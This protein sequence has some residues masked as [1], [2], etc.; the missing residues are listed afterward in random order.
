MNKVTF[1]FKQVLSQ[2]RGHLGEKWNF[3][4]EGSLLSSPIVEDIDHDGKKEILFGTKDGKL[5]LLSMDGKIKWT[6]SITEKINDV[7]LMFLDSDEMHSINATPNIGDIN[8]DKKNEILFGSE[9]GFLYALN[10]FGQLLWKFKTDGPVRSSVLIEDLNNDG[11]KEII[12]GSMDNFLY[13]LGSTGKLLMKLKINSPIEST[14]GVMKN[15]SK[16]IIFGSDDGTVYSVDYSGRLLWKFKTNGKI[17]AQPLIVDLFNDGKEYVII[18]SFDNFLYC[19]DNQGK[20]VWQFKTEGSI[21]SKAVSAD[22][23]NDQ[24]PEVVFGSCDNKVYALRNDGEKIWDY[25]TDF[26]VVASPIISDMDGDGKPEIIVGSY[27]H[28]IYVL[29]SEG[30]YVLDYVPGISGAVN[31]AGNYSEIPTQDPGRIHGKKI[32]QYETDGIIV[33]CAI[34]NETNEIIVNNKIGK[35]KNISHKKG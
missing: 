8:N 20:L 31:Q 17:T 26:W 16:Q 6:Y 23:N 12:F 2:K 7:E 10:H 29:D 5:Y 14:P 34:V 27:D 4:S 21:C 32:W 25:E 18:G 1:G 19:L 15:T 24:K 13:V 33:G 9:L 30:S 28:N 11:H 3:V 22:I 35:V